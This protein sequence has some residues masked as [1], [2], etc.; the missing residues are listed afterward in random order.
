MTIRIL[1]YDKQVFTRDSLATEIKAGLAKLP[2]AEVSTAP[3]RATE[4]GLPA[5]VQAADYTSKDSTGREVPFR[6]LIAIIEYPDHLILL[7]YLGPGSLFG[8]Y[9]SA[10]EMVGSTLRRR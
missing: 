3:V 7:G 9:M 5:R 4:G 8:K 1:F 10:F 2:G 6:Q